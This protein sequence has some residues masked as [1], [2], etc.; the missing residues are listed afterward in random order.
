MKSPCTL[1]PFFRQ[2]ATPSSPLRILCAYACCPWLWFRWR[3]RGVSIDEH[4]GGGQSHAPLSF[5]HI[6]SS[7]LSSVKIRRSQVPSRVM[8]TPAPLFSPSRKR[9]RPCSVRGLLL[10]VA[11]R[12]CSVQLLLIPQTA[13]SQLQKSCI[14]H[15]R[16]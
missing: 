7:L 6:S 14:V 13:P 3:L 2:A 5:S 1:Y 10:A 11:H 9:A 8:C 16:T 15:A 12:L 4:R